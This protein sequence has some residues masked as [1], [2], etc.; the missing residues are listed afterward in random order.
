MGSARFH[1]G[2]RA[3]LLCLILGLAIRAHA[4]LPADFE[5]QLQ[6]AEAAQEQRQPPIT[7]L[8]SS[9]IP[10]CPTAQLANGDGDVST[11]GM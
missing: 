6:R 11:I 2:L 10:Q 1:L 5:T 4:Q 7:E 9:I 3:V 8:Q